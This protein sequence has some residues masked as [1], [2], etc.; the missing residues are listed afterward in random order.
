M[1]NPD[2]LT[3]TLDDVRR[4][5]ALGE[6]DGFDPV[7]ALLRMS[8]QPRPTE[9]PPGIA[10]RQAAVLLLLFP[11]AEGALHF[12]LMR[13]QEYPGVHSGQISLP[14]GRQEVG[15][16]YV[17]TA[18]REAEEEVGVLASDVRVIGSLTPFYI[19]PSNFEIHPIVGAISYRPPWNLHAYE[20]AELIETPL[21]VLFDE[22]LKGEEMMQRGDAVFRIHFY[23][24]GEAK[25]WGATAAILGEFEARLR[26]ALG[27]ERG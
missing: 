14:G 6:A 24:L 17:H 2:S 26:W 16:T 13:R 4:A 1:P 22:A 8:P 18:L 19:P 23:R 9:P 5:L 3:I 21:D 15:E 20:V 7:R 25:V 11:G 10:A 12:P 27:T